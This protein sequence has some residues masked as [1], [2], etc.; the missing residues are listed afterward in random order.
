MTGIKAWI[1][2]S[3]LPSQSY[4]FL[5]I[6]LGQAIWVFQGNTLD[7]LAF[8]LVQLFGLFDQLY[9]FYANDYADFSADRVNTSP[10]IFSGGSRVLVEGLL[11]PVQLKIAAIIMVVLCLSCAV[12]F[13]LLLGYHYMIPLMIAAILLLWIY[14]YKPFRQSYRGGGEVLQA[15]GTGLLLPLIGYYAQSGTLSVFPWNLL[16]IILPTSLSCAIATALPDEP[17]DA[18]CSK[19]TIVVMVGLPR[20]KLIIFIL[21]IISIVSLCFFGVVFGS[22]I[23]DVPACFFPVA[24]LLG[25]VVFAG[26]KPGT[27]KIVAFVS[28]AIFTT[29]SLIGVVTIGL[30]GVTS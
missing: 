8:I 13:S 25:M 12:L 23:L 22:R 3:R 30:F 14:S 19:N 4:I 11:K 26:G 9:I 16:L 5:P 2:A 10:T 29:L 7:P 17:A 18:K 20:A 27:S 24:G 15:A 21:N 1:Q 28:L 6:L